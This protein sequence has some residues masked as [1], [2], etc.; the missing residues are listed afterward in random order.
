MEE[1]TDDNATRKSV[2]FVDLLVSQRDP[3]GKPVYASLK[4][5]DV[6]GDTFDTLKEGEALRLKDV[7]V[8][9]T[10]IH[11]KLQITMNKRSVFQR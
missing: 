5:W 10:R 8:K 1:E 7:N 6:S 2:P 11:G 4:F 9:T 3:G